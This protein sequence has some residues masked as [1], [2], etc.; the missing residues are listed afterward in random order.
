[1][2]TYPFDPRTVADAATQPPLADLAL[3]AGRRARRRRLLGSAL[4]VGGL[5]LGAAVA[6]PV[7]GGQGRDGVPAADARAEGTFFTSTVVADPRTVVAVKW[8][9]CAVAVSVSTDAGTTWTPYRGPVEWRDCG[10]PVSSSYQVLTPSLYVA[11]VQW[12]R[13]L[14]RDAGVTWQRA[15][16]RRHAVEVLPAEAE[17]YGEGRESVDRVTGDLYQLSSPDFPLPDVWALRATPDGTLWAVGDR[18]TSAQQTQAPEVVR[19]ADRGRTWEPAGQPP[20]TGGTPLLVA[21]DARRAYLLGPGVV[22]RT[23]DGGVSW[24]TA[25]A[26]WRVPLTAT[27]NAA[28]ALLICERRSDGGFT[29]WASRDGGRTFDRGETVSVPG[30]PTGGH[31]AGLLWVAGG[32]GSAA[33]STDG[34]SWQRTRPRPR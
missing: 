32:D 27:V 2:P 3:R 31:T 22:H 15:D 6:V 16:D 25:G 10:I 11:T 30:A 26:P 5:A 19:S 28:G 29:A 9:E 1:M 21:G 17:P 13:Y 24:A 8:S 20:S 14:S 4:A 34:R 18:V 23:R 33:L 7:L 12:Q